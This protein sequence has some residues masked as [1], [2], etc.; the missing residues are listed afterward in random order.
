ML[1]LAMGNDSSSLDSC[2]GESMLM[3]DELPCSRDNGGSNGGT[4]PRFLKDLIVSN[5]LTIEVPEQQ[6]K[7]ND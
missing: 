6:S 3:T 5:C 7:S 2:T 1:V 4:A